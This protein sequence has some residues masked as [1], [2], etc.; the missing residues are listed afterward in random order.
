MPRE[1]I[2]GLSLLEDER[3]YLMDYF[4]NG[5]S[6]KLGELE[7]KAYEKAIGMLNKNMDMTR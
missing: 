1:E 3:D 6:K 2:L 5:T 7:K 4:L